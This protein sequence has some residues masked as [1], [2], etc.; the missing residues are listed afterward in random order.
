[1][2]LQ[3]IF[4]GVVIIVIIALMFRNGR[5]RQRD[6]AAMNTGLKPGAEIM[7]ASGIFGRIVS[8]DEEENKVVI[9]THPGSHLTIHRQAIGRIVTPVAEDGTE[10]NG[11]PVVLDDAAADPAFG[12]RVEP[13]TT[14]DADETARRTGGSASKGA[15]E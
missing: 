9:E 1:M 2:D 15:G 5:K 3:L 11:E 10:L 13:S 6:A 4:F 8:F 12:E 14:T 7:T